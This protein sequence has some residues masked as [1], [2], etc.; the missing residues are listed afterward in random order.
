M[1]ENNVTRSDS[2]CLSDLS[3]TSS[4]GTDE[5]NFD[6]VSNN[7]A[8]SDDEISMSS[9]DPS[10]TVTHLPACNNH[11][12]TNAAAP[13]GAIRFV[14]LNANNQL[15]RNPTAAATMV[16]MSKANIMSIQEHGISFHGC[17]ESF[18]DSI[19]K[20]GYRAIFAEKACLIYDHDLIGAC[21]AESGSLLKG[22]LIWSVFYFSEYNQIIILSIYGVAYCGSNTMDTN[23]ASYMTRKELL[24]QT[25]RRLLHLKRKYSGAKIVILGDLQDTVHASD[26]LGSYKKDWKQNPNSI[27]AIAITDEN[28]T[29]I[30]R[31]ETTK[32]GCKYT[33]RRGNVAANSGERSGRGIDHIFISDNIESEYGHNAGIDWDIFSEMIHSDHAP[34][35]A[36]IGIGAD[37]SCSDNTPT[38][39]TRYKE[40]ANIPVIRNEV[41]DP[42]FNDLVYNSFEAGEQR[43]LLDKLLK[44]T[45]DEKCKNQIDTAFEVASNLEA[46]VIKDSQM[47]SKEEQEAGFRIERKPVYRKMLNEAMKHFNTAISTAFAVAN[48]SSTSSR[49]DSIDSIRKQRQEKTFIPASKRSPLPLCRTLVS[50]LIAINS[51]TVTIGLLI[52]SL[53]CETGQSRE[54]KKGKIE[55]QKERLKKYMP[56]S[57]AVSAAINE[58]MLRDYEQED[59]QEAIASRRGKRTLDYARS[60]IWTFEVC[61]DDRKAFKAVCHEASTSLGNVYWDVDAN[62]RRKTKWEKWK[63]LAES[64][65][66]H[67]SSLIRFDLSPGANFKYRTHR[68]AQICITISLNTKRLISSARREIQANFER[69]AV[70]LGNIQKLG[71]IC[72]IL[73][74]KQTNKPTAATSFLDKNGKEQPALSRDDRLQGTLQKEAKMMSPDGGGE[75]FT[76]H[77]ATSKQDDCGPCGVNV[78]VDKEYTRENFEKSYPNQHKKWYDDVYGLV[79]DAHKNMKELFRP[80]AE[81]AKEL[82]WPWFYEAKSGVFSDMGLIKKFDKMILTTPTKERHGGFSLQ[83]LGRLPEK[84]ARAFKSIMRSTLVTRLYANDMKRTTRIPIPKNGKP[85]ETRPISI[86]QDA[87]CY[88]SSIIQ[89]AFSKG[90]ES[91]TL[92]NDNLFAYRKGF[93]SVDLLSCHLAAMEDIHRR[94]SGFFNYV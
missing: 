81:H 18:N 26:V 25:R 32:R 84:F 50:F 38:Q 88:I 30:V 74:R 52:K 15:A 64:I 66:E 90:L 21:L 58:L 1:D 37:V 5:M 47:Q 71:S 41:G 43:V 7:Q 55:E 44:A 17:I 42:A 78:D 61:K 68:I 67:L 23:S 79:A 83:V 89:D 91:A 76:M 49:K 69:N 53:S 51:I 40:I 94:L 2:S 10:P 73:K 3:I 45:K 93:S 46:M 63:R 62:R 22:R 54:S 86:C 57:T 11:R 20:A 14:S 82:E 80:P 31:E 9:N 16:C 65:G 28:M 39:R 12:P 4:V 70:H 59:H 19:N 24:G 48:L 33:T 56:P 36:D 85:N 6:D 8:E 72:Q 92:L 29:S 34:I 87:F 77:F 13:Y 60:P 27:L 35:W 75:D